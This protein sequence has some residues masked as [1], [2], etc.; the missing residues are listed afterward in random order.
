MTVIVHFVEK[1]LEVIK[2]A[3]SVTDFSNGVEIRT[4]ACKIVRHEKSKIDHIDILWR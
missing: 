4:D 3:K 2:D 1:E